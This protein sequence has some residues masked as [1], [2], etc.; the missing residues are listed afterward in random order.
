MANTWTTIA[1]HHT[2]WFGFFR[3]SSKPSPRNLAV[4]LPEKL[5]KG[6]LATRP[7]KKLL[8]LNGGGE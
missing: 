7:R 3:S 5:L 2:R 6:E 1:R 4:E 8:A